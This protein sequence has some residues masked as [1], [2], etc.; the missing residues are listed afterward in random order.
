MISKIKALTVHLKLKV[1]PTKWFSRGKL[2]II[3]HF[4]LKDD[5][6]WSNRA[7][8]A[9]LFSHAFKPFFLHLI[10]RGRC[11]ES[12]R[13]SERMYTYGYLVSLHMNTQMSRK[14]YSYRTVCTEQCRKKT[15]PPTVL[16]SSPSRFVW[17][18]PWPLLTL[19]QINAMYYMHW[20]MQSIIY[21][22][23]VVFDLHHSIGVRYCKT[24][25]V[26]PT[27]LG[28]IVVWIRHIQ[29]TNHCLHGRIFC[30]LSS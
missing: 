5:I 23:N 30:N 10:F 6:G 20:Y 19:F 27:T 24:S 11:L 2:C 25:E 21:L 26:L 14:K 28:S 4:V 8:N 7:V 15:S 13:R 3:L 17:T 9:L 16:S 18:R 1:F 29:F 22:D 12:S